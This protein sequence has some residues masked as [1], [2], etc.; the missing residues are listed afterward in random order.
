MTIYSR[1]SRYTVIDQEKAAQLANDMI[2][3]W[4]LRRPVAKNR[5]ISFPAAMPKELSLVVG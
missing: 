4:P 5:S 2:A 1:I 3:S